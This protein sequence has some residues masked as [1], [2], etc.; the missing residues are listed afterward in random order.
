[1]AEPIPSP[2]EAPT[3]SQSNEIF[4]EE[5]L[6]ETPLSHSSNPD[7]R[8]DSAI[9]VS[10]TS[11]CSTLVKYKSVDNSYFVYPPL[12][13]GHGRLVRARQTI[14]SYAGILI[15]L[16]MLLWAFWCAWNVRPSVGG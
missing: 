7:Y 11:S 2:L 8:F 9:Q 13:T 10:P 6:I 5:T 12:I 1:M 16:A 14:P 15:I 3:L 4:D